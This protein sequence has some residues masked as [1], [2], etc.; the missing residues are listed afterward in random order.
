[1]SY[2]ISLPNLTAPTTAGQIQQLHAYLYQL[3]GQLNWAL[4]T[5]EG[6]YSSDLTKE[7][8]QATFDAIKPLISS[9]TDILAAYST[10]LCNGVRMHSKA[11]SGTKELVI[12][13]RYGAFGGQDDERQ[14]FF[15][16]G[17][18]NS[19]LVYGVASVS[20]NGTTQWSGTTGV[21]LTTKSGGILTVVLPE[22]A[23]DIFTII[24][25]RDFSV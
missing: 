14:T 10:K 1:M 25:G 19:S 22:V 4:N 13:T 2:D 23:N 6:G 24:S 3:A 21:T 20:N 12:G 15:I 11:V 9:S 7:Q 5:I 18:A 16:F 8:A 17:A